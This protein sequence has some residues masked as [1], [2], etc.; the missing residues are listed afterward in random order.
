MGLVLQIRKLS[1]RI[2]RYKISTWAA[3]YQDNLRLALAVNFD[4]VL[5]QSPTHTIARHADHPHATPIF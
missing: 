2:N 1:L 4:L 5:R 3:Q